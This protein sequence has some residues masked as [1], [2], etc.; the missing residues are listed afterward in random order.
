MTT[1]HSVK[2]APS[3][4]S[5]D[6]GQFAAEAQRVQQA[7]ADWIHCDV[8]DGHFVPNITFGPDTIHMLRRNTTLPLDVHL[9]IQRPERYVER[10]IDAGADHVTI[11]VEDEARSDVS[12]TLSLIK[13]R[14]KRVG[15]SLNPPTPVEKILPFLNHLDLVLVMTVNPGFGGQ[16]FIPDGLAKIR[17]LRAAINHHNRH[18]D[19]VVDGGINAQTGRLCV[20]AGANVLV[21]GN[22]LFHHKS[23]DL[24]NAICELRQH[25]QSQD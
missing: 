13:N 24:L 22:S 17:A 9:M 11:H 15:L 4:L 2:I 12:W 25:A 7:G 8:M 14:G 20:Q 10:F 5:A 19:I 16:S 1:S 18:I 3:I 6:F 21:A 23:L